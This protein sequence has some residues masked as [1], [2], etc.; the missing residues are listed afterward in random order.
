MRRLV[1]AGLDV[2]LASRRSCPGSPTTSAT[3]IDLLGRVARGRRV[4]TVH[5]VLFLRS[6][7]K[8]KYLRLLAQE[9]PRLPRGLP[10]RLR[11]RA[12]TWAAATATTIDALVQRLTEKHGF[13]TERWRDRGADASS[14]ASGTDARRLVIESRCMHEPSRW[15]GRDAGPAAARQGAGQRHRRRAGR[16]AGRRRGRRSPATIPLRGVMLGSAHPKLFCPGLDLVEPRRLRPRGLERL[17]AAL[18]GDGAG[19]STGSGAGG[20]RARRTRG[21]RRLHPGP[22]RRRSRRSCA[23][24]RSD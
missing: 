24:R 15:R 10:A 16:G 19:R 22:D 14:C 2:W 21:G 4:A 5:N 3:S 11:R 18:R 6:P 1:E 23:A 20:G 12:S 13:R 7:T 8:E 9:F 17:H